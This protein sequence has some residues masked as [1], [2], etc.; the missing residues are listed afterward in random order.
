MHHTW[1]NKRETLVD[2][3]KFDSISVCEKVIQIIDDG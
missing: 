1:R 3:L 2:A